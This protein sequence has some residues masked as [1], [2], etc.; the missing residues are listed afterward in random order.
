M[1]NTKK[2]FKDMD[3]EHLIAT[4]NGDVGN[5]GWTNSRASFCSAMAEEFERRHYDYSAIGKKNVS[6]SWARKIKLVGKKIVLE[7][8]A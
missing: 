1:K 4:F 7:E 6:L 5:P 2:R 8:P 3:D